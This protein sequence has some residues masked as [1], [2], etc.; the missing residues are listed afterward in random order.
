LADDDSS[1]LKMT[2]LRLEHEGYEVVVAH[3]GEDA[4]RQIAANNAIDLILLDLKMPKLNGLEVCQRLKAQP[5]TAA[6]PIILFTASETFM[7]QLTDRCIELGAADWIKKP[8]RSPELLARI[9]KAIDAQGPMSRVTMGRQ[10]RILVVDDDQRI[11]EFF[12]QAIPNTD[13]EVV[14]VGS[15]QEAVAAV[16]AAPFDLAFV[17]IIM[18][19]MDGLETLKALRAQRPHLP[20]I[21]M[22][23]YEVQDIVNLALHF[24]AIDCLYKPFVDVD[25]ILSALEQCQQ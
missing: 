20:V 6:I 24:G 17:D 13:Y 7:E 16:N 21:M 4:L 23:G 18:P 12:S 3:D 14:A 10:R 19:G 5:E 8:F 1:I 25:K 9:R 11:H 22:T 2:K 15:G